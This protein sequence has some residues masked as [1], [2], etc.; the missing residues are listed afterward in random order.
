LTVAK[1]LLDEFYLALV[2]PS[3]ECLRGKGPPDRIVGKTLA[4][5]V[6][7]SIYQTWIQDLLLQDQDQDQDQDLLIQDQDQDQDSEVPRPRPRPR[8]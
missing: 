4:P 6:S 3:G 2:A 1:L 7:G 5:S 8:L